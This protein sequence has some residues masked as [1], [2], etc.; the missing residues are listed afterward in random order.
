MTTRLDR[1]I[2]NLQQALADA[3]SIIAAEVELAKSTVA[4]HQHPNIP[5][6]TVVDV[7]VVD[8]P[9]KVLHPSQIATVWTKDRLEILRR[10]Y[11]AG[12]EIDV[13]LERLNALPAEK[14][15]KRG[16]IAVK[17]AG[18]GWRR[19]QPSA[20]AAE[21]AIAAAAP[22]AVVA[23]ELATSIAPPAPSSVVETFREALAADRSAKPPA[24]VPRTTAAK[25]PAASVA[26][27]KWS[28]ERLA[29]ARPLYEGDATISLIVATVN[30]LPGPDVTGLQ[31]NMVAAAHGWTRG[32][33]QMPPSEPVRANFDQIRQWAGE[34]GIAVPGRTL[35]MER[36]NAKRVY[37]GMPPFIFEPAMRGRVI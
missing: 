5:V 29:A 16:T 37:L 3:F 17:A 28:D 7:E 35:P 34:R 27:D 26:P 10:D 6:R 18:K 14:P 36:I 11:T 1:A 9:A 32:Q 8:V 12:V 22:V 21:S 13:I 19:P 30:A 33:R 31:I 23:P 24:P 25:P 2:A 20:A 4:P 15:V